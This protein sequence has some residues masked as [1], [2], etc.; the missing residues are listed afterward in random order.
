MELKREYTLTAAPEAV[1]DALGDPDVIAKCIPGCESVE[2]VSDGELKAVVAV[3]IGPFRSRFT[4]NIRLTEAV[5]PRS[6]V[7]EAEGRG[8]PAGTARGN[9]RVNLTEKEG[10]TLLKVDGMAELGGK[11]ADVVDSLVE[12]FAREMANTFFV[13]LDEEMEAKSEEWVDQLDHSPAGV[14][15][16]DEPSED[17]VVDKAERAGA[18]AE[19][20]ENQ[21]ET[22]AGQ[23]V[24]GGPYVWGLLAVVV[25]IIILVV[26]N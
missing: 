22:A 21:V 6:G 2:R 18:A 14:L 17:V 10:G 5:R 15:L 24:W 9:A 20:V 8:R 25:L 3:E 7:L 16:G 12:D 4:G 23:G 13:R 1:W 26:A 19:Q 11:L